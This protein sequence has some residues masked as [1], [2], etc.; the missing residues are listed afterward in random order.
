MKLHKLVLHGFKSF[1]DRTELKFHDGITAVVGPN[2][3][4]KSNISDAIRW[5]L[6]EQRAS[7]IRG[8]K[9]EDAIFQGT[10]QRRAVNRAEVALVFDNLEGRLPIA[11][12]EIE[13]R[14]TV[15]R[16][17]GSDYQ[18]NRTPSRL[19]DILDMCRDTGLGANAYTVIEQGM[20]DAVLSDRADERR[21]L[22]E[23]AAGIGRYKDRRKAAQRRLEA[24]EQDLSRL[25]DLIGEVESKVRS[26]ARQSKKAQRYAT[27]RT[28]RLSL[29]IAVATAELE[30]IRST[31][32]ETADRLEKLQ[33]DDPSGRAALAA[34]E[35]ELERRRLEAAESARVRSVVASKHEDATRR[36][37]ERERE[38]AVA[39]ER[40]A[41]AEHRL[42][43]IAAEREELR[44]RAERLRDDVQA[45]ESQ[46]TQRQQEVAEVARRAETVQQAQQAVRAQL[47]EA[48]SADEQTRAKEKELIG[49][50][51]TL[52]ASVAAGTARATEAESRLE[53]MQTEQEELQ[54]AIA[55][56]DAQGDLFAD[57]VRRLAASADERER[58]YAAALSRLDLVR[59]REAEARRALNDAEERAQRLA[60][61]LA[62]LE[63]LER[64]FHGYTPAVAG[65]LQARGQFDGLIGPLAEY[66]NLDAQRAAAFEGA[67]GSLLQVLVVRDSEASARVRAWLDEHRPGGA[68][69]LLPE[70]AVAKLEELFAILE[71]AGEPAS[72]PVVLGRRERLDALRR[73]VDAAA[74]ERDAAHARRAEI[75]V[76]VEAA[77]AALR[78]AD[79]RRHELDLELRRLESD[80][81]S[82]QGRHG[83]LQRARVELERR[84]TELQHLLERSRR[85]AQHAQQARGELLVDL[86]S[87]RTA[88]Q[89]T[90]RVVVER[91]L[92]WEAARDEEAEVR[93]QLARAEGALSEVERR[94]S[95]A[96]S[97]LE[98]TGARSASLDREESEHLSSIERLEALHAESSSALEMLFAERDAVTD[99]LRALDEQLAAATQATDSLE[100]QVRALR[101]EAEERGEI[102]HRLEILRTETEAAQRRVRDRLEA[103]W[104]RPFQQL[105][106][107]ALPVEEVVASLKLRP[108][109]ASAEEDAED[110]ETSHAESAEDAALS[111]TDSAA[112]DLSGV[113]LE[114]PGA[115]AH[116]SARH[117]SET[118]SEPTPHIEHVKAL[119][120]Q[121][122][123]DIEK[124]GPI[125]ML[126]IE[127]H[128]EE[129]ARLEFLQT[130]RNDLEKARDDLQTAIRQINRTARQ[131]FMETFEQVRKNFQVTFDAL[132]EG[133]ECDVTLADEE[134]PLESDIDVSASPRG[135]RTQRIHLLS[136]GERAL[137]ALALLF[138]IYLVKP[139]P[140]CVLDEVDAPLDEANIGRFVNMLQQFKRQ[141][142]F[143]VITHN[144]R[145]MEAADWIYGVTM[146]EPGISSIV[147]VQMEEAVESAQVADEARVVTIA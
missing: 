69:A 48:R 68:V 24:A 102:R 32:T 115:D 80:E 101:R 118:E 53:R 27:L 83:Q 11:Q 41:H 99:E 65:I 3:C 72:E 94:L 121:V 7:A 114:G 61:Q 120:R 103:E 139:S 5:V 76:Q 135:K 67:L 58:E 127:E 77:D 82:R 14:R 40:R 31:L 141:T 146:A 98:S 34:A 47:A 62:A 49:R 12:D 119:L 137:T 55:D 2:G 44:A 13:V 33:R 22:F 74:R 70:S 4:G 100:V 92:K 140:F 85:E 125:N 116:A 123:G 108:P 111:V 90:S 134:D 30:H 84:R 147:G 6:G 126:A 129:S 51:A 143:I 133:G 56:L 144:P 52:E 29:E 23:E 138:A 104:A 63:A 128:A 16:E 113:Q 1:A 87:H 110:A 18:L 93:V 71:F 107:E 97:S 64:E 130:Q 20:V 35:T 88:A 25:N 95:D 131:L 132:F 79:T 60:A 46:R 19:R 28:Q 124:L 78:A 117:D 136:G 112:G 59:E 109:R 17:G 50:L 36:I 15:F 43:Q 37:G 57:H 38:L 86:E 73:E 54:S 21:H 96:R 9:M 105:V 26:L 10:Q 106:A 122:A 89:E 145:T 45:L 39:H 66:L 91:E 42:G 81:S 142:Q 75:G 8:S